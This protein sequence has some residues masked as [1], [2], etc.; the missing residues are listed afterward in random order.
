MRLCC[1]EIITRGAVE[2]SYLYICMGHTTYHTTKIDTVELRSVGRGHRP[3]PPP[4]YARRMR[5][6]RV[7]RALRGPGP[8]KAHPAKRKQRRVIPNYLLPTH[9]AGR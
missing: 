1:E 4:L 5:M 3:P 7:R 6:G 2:T 8:P 9:A